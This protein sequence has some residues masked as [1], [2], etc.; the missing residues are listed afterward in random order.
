MADPKKLLDDL[1]ND[2]SSPVAFAGIDVLWREA[3]KIYKRLPRSAVID[4]LQGH[5]TYTLHRPRR[6]RF[7]RSKTIASGFMT[8]V[9]VDLGYMLKF[10]RDNNGYKYFMLGIDV[11]SKRIFVVPMRTKKKEE[12]VEAFKAL[13]AQMPMKPWRIF[14]DL[15]T[16]FHNELVEEFMEQEDIAKV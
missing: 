4:Y 16:E 1:Y 10:A 2:P 6:V 14:T 8:D 13:I 11:L 7:K 15:G 3:R 12:A 9:Q 5:R